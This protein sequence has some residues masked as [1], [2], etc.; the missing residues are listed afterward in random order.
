MANFVRMTL[1]AALVAGIAGCSTEPT[2]AVQPAA[3]EQALDSKVTT[4]V[5]KALGKAGA[6]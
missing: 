1:L 5:V 6:W 2:Q 4:D 3:V